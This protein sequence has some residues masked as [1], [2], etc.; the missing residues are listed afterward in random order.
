MNVNIPHI[1][2]YLLKKKF[3][4][5]F[6]DAGVS[7]SILKRIFKVKKFINDHAI[8]SYGDTLAKIN[9]KHLMKN[10]KKSK[11]VMTIVVAPIQ[12]PFGL[13]K[14]DALTK[15]TNFEEKPVL[16]HYIGYAV[17]SP[18]FFD[19]LNASTIN[20]KDGKGII[21]IIKNLILK[22]QLNIYKFN[23]LQVTINS[24]EELKY[25]RLN[26]KKYFTL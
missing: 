6:S 1:H 9:F 4:C 5:T 18:N 11:C 3:H 14:W 7:A 10:H 21:K 26:Y 12:N 22:K 17:I 20:L 24:P 15:A 23:K 25:A 19:K 2:H 13:V 16:N 8:I